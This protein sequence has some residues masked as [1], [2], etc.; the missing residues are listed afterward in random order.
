MC[1]TSHSFSS[2]FFI[3]KNIT[4]VYVTDLDHCSVVVSFYCFR[5]IETFMNRIITVEGY[6]L[7]VGSQPD[8]SKKR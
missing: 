5:N 8:L 1:A 4:L 2:F 7:C 6:S 3:R